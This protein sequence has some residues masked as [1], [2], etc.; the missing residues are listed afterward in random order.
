MGV[1]KDY[2]NTKK[3]AVTTSDNIGRKQSITFLTEKGLYKVL[4]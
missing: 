4:L 2:N 3:D 1:I